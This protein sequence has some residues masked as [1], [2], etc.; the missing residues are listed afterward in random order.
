MRTFL[1]DVGL[2]TTHSHANRLNLVAEKQV[3]K[4]QVRLKMAELVHPGFDALPVAVLTA[5][6]EGP[7]DLEAHILFGPVKHSA[8]L[9]CAGLIFQ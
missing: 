6:S 4:P 5:F 8:I 2:S 3:R 9:E 1:I 7:G